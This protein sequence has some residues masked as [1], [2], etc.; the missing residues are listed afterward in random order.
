[1]VRYYTD[2]LGARVQ[3]ENEF[4]AFLTYDD[5]HHRIALLQAP[6]TQN[7]VKGTCGLEHIAFTFG[8]LS[9]LLLSY[10][11]R[12]SKGIMPLWPVNHGPTTSIYYRDPDGNELETQ[13]DNFKDADEA[14][15]FMKSKAFADN[16]IGV[17]FDPE[18]F[19]TRLQNGEKEEV[20]MKRPQSGPRGLPDHML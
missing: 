16:P 1:M 9:D 20:L 18:E 2:F 15:E 7:R 13:V 12:K 10:R 17:D 8:S 19:I 3:Y 6:G 14:T 5:E 11:Q 4:L